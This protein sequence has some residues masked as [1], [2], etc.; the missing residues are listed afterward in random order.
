MMAKTAERLMKILDEKDELRE[1]AIKETRDIVRASRETISAIH[2]NRPDVKA[3]EGAKSK[4]K[5]L[6]ESLKDHGDI[7]FSG[8]IQNAAQELAEAFLLYRYVKDEEP[9]SPEELCVEPAD[10]LLGLCDFVGELRRHMLC[11]LI[12]KDLESASRDCKAIER[13]Y[14]TLAVADYPKGLINLKQ[15]VDACRAIMEKSFEDLARARQ[16]TEL[17]RLLSEKFSS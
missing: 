12:K 10:Y 3:I 4:L 6:K 1:R 14:A 8:Y 16:S 13:I 15:K 9:P 2:D 17:I 11:S 5:A 7:L